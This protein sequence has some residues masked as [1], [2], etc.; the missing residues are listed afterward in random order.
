[1]KTYYSDVRD[2]LKLVYESD[3]NGTRGIKSR[4]ADRVSALVGYEGAGKSNFGLVKLLAW[5]DFIGKKLTAKELSMQISAKPEE[6]ARIIT[7]SKAYDMIM[8]DEGV[9]ITYGRNA[10]S[11]VSKNINT[12]LMVCRAKHFYIDILIPNFLDLD[13]YVRKNRVTS[14]W[15]MLPDYRVAY[16]SK[17]RVRK[18]LGKMAFDNRS[19]HHADPMKQGV[20]PNFIATVPLCDNVELVEAYNKI[21]SNNM[22][23]VIANTVKSITKESDK[24]QV[25]EKKIDAR[26][27]TIMEGLSQNKPV[28]DI[29]RELGISYHTVV[30]RIKKL[31]SMG[32]DPY[33]HHTEAELKDMMM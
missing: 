23:Q 12:L 28:K 4:G 7:T 15:V 24:A 2:A 19:G 10:M 11:D 3:L 26:D 25:K 30:P 27:K 6:F 5:Y 21:K 22:E 18:L 17:K 9:L 14:L 31:K 1:M 32:I 20:L 8:V 29:A 16:F 33:Q 13:T